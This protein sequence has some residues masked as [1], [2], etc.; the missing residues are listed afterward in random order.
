MYTSL[1]YT[2][3]SNVISVIL[4]ASLTLIY[5]YFGYSCIDARLN[6]LHMSM[7]RVENYLFFN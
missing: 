7:H 5:I 4:H 6:T 3:F 1:K 2:Y